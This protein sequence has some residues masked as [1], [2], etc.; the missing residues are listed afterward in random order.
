MKLYGLIG[1]PLGHSFS[2]KYFTEKFSKEGITDCEYDNFSIPDIE[3]LKQVLSEHPQLCGFNITIPHKQAVLSFLD[4]S[5]HLPEGLSACNCVKIEAGKLIGYN[6][7][8]AGF[9]QS[10]SPLL[11]SNH[12]KALILGNGGAAEAVKFVLNKLQIG[13]KVVSRRLHDDTN[14]LYRDLDDNKIKDHLLIVNTT[15]IGT[16]PKAEECPDIPYQS[17]TTNHYLFDLVY[18]PAKTLFLQK[19]E[20]RGA[21]IKNGSDML[22]IQAEESWKIWNENS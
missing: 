21:I 2:K 4:D 1:Y 9:E 8:V 20:E 18:N 5:T 11:N 13:F 16:F 15:P 19:G 6:T 7:D 14:L 17:I 10:L 22:Q 12:K 3:E